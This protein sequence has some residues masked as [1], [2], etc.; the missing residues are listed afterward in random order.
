[1]N[2]YI[3]ISSPIYPETEPNPI[4]NHFN[5]KQ[6]NGTLSYS[7]SYD[8]ALA[9]NLDAVVLSLTPGSGGLNFWT[10][11]GGVDDGFTSDRVLALDLDASGNAYVSGSTYAADFPATP[12]SFDNEFDDSCLCSDGFVAMLSSDGSAL[13][14]ATFLG[15]DGD[16]IVEDLKLD[17]GSLALTGAT[18]SSDFPVTGDAF[19]GLLDGGSDAFVA[20]LSGSGAALPYATFLGGGDNE[21][22]L[23]VDVTS[24]GWLLVTGWAVSDDFPTTP[25]SFD[26]QHNFDKDVFVTVLI[27]P[28]ALP[29]ATLF[30]PSVIR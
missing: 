22:G 25:G 18:G 11:L 4:E 2:Y 8:T 1:L 3:S 30:L 15:G 26:T 29:L 28:G 12:G 20:R 24:G 6:Q 16:D 13:L 21:A 7:S 23:G 9:G 5:Q 19:D 17:S 27:P 14:W 10:Y